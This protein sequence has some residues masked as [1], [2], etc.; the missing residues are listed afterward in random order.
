MK[1]GATLFL[2]ALLVLVAWILWP[3]DENA[4]FGSGTATDPT[5]PQPAP[6]ISSAGPSNQAGEREE[7]AEADAPE[8]GQLV[9]VLDP[10]GKPAPRVQVWFREIGPDLEDDLISFWAS[11][12]ESLRPWP[13][14]G[15]YP[16]V[17]TDQDGLAELSTRG[18]AAV[19]V[20]VP[21]AMGATSFPGLA[22]GAPATVHLLQLKEVPTV[23]VLVL[24]GE[25]QPVSGREV[26]LRLASQASL[27]TLEGEARVQKRYLGGVWEDPGLSG[28]SNDEG[29]VLLPLVLDDKERE[30]L[31]PETEWIAEA[32]TEINTYG[33]IRTEAAIPHQGPIVLRTPSTGELILELL[34]FPAGVV[35]VVRDGAGRDSNGAWPAPPS[36]PGR[37]HF[38]DVP[39][40]E[41]LLVGF[42]SA[43]FDPNSGRV[44][45][46]SATT[47][48][49]QRIIGPDVPNGLTVRQLRHEREPGIYGRLVIPQHRQAHIP[50]NGLS[51]FELRGVAPLR[52]QPTPEIPFSVYPDGSFFVPMQS[53][54]RQGEPLELIECEALLFEWTLR[55]FNW[56]DPGDANRRRTL[57]A[58][59]A[60]QVDSAQTIVEVGEV[61]LQE[62]P[63]LLQ[64]HVQDSQGEPVSGAH[65][66][67]AY[68][69]EVFRRSGA[70]RGK[71]PN[72]LYTDTAGDVW[73]QDRSW[74]TEFGLPRSPGPGA[75]SDAIVEISVTVDHQDYVSKTVRID[76]KRSSWTIELES[77]SAVEGSYLPLDAGSP[78][79]LTWLPVGAPITS[80]AEDAVYSWVMRPADFQIQQGLAEFELEGMPVGSWDLVV[81]IGHLR[82]NEVLRV[83][84]V[85]VVLGELCEDPRLQ[86]MDFRAAVDLY[87]FRLV[88]GAGR[89]VAPPDIQG[90]L[91]YR[92]GPDHFLDS[93]PTVWRDGGFALAEPQ[94]MELDVTLVDPRWLSVPLRGVGPGERRMTVVPRQKRE[95]IVEVGAE[96]PPELEWKAT[97]M[98][99]QPPRDTMTVTFNQQG[100]GSATLPAA[101]G[102]E[103]GWAARIDGRWVTADGGEI[104][105][106]GETL[107]TAS[108]LRLHPPADFMQKLR[109]GMDGS[110]R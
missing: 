95:V 2:A 31:G 71:S 26:E 48:P 97:L 108:P 92:V 16:S 41:P 29:R 10:E 24:N 89:S 53:V 27:A 106:G 46:S 81:S 77:A 68:V 110:R 7:L 55:R 80:D 69:Q 63:V 39:V 12:P 22:P 3:R 86:R 76:P 91:L 1:R 66:R 99:L 64:I 105:I 78:V 20:V 37:F 33:T 87:A 11:E 50:M 51:G 58:D 90:R 60:I 19:A 96:L 57:F 82:T 8:G 79:W 72:W 100:T 52:T 54:T 98:S 25:E 84:A 9:Q 32:R 103:L 49:E 61:Y 83:P 15:A 4:P 38:E 65:V 56:N 30:R 94:G 42:S 6:A 93:G 13:M 73:F 47:L 85:Q 70:V 35:P 109:A 45:S 5:T 101:G 62:A 44:Q 74:S 40:R 43:E 34:D 88:D 75:A 18:A 28:V 17:Q 104:M 59:L 36:E 21:G 107:A 23:E 14:Q 67:L 102:Y